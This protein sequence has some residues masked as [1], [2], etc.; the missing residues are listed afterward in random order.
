VNL[1]I[2]HDWWDG[3]TRVLA[4][5]VVLTIVPAACVLWFMNAAVTNDAAAAQERVL[6]AYRG[7]LH[8]VRSRLDALWRAQAERL[9]APGDPSREFQRLITNQIAEGAVVLDASGYVTFP[10]TD[11]RGDLAAID[12]RVAAAGHLDAAARDTAVTEIAARL[13]DY[14]KHLPAGDRLRLMDDLRAL[15]P[16]VWLPTQ[17]ALQLSLDMV[18][19]ERPEPVP[20][21]VRKA[22]VPD[23]WAL[24]SRDRR[25][26]GLYRTGRIEAILHDFLHQ[27][28]PEGVVFVAYPPDVV[29]DAEAI[30]AGP[31]LPGWQ[32]SMVPLDRTLF[33]GNA[34]RQRTI[35]VSVALGGIALMLVVGVI[36]GRSMRR[37]L[38]VARLKTDLA[39]AVSHELRTP[40]ASMRVLVDGLLADPSPDP[41]KTRDYLQLMAIENERLTRLIDNFLTF[42]R[43][44]RRPRRFELAPVS[45]ADLVH[46]ALD[47]VRARMPASCELRVDVQP[48]LP[49][50]LADQQGITTALVNL[51]DNAIKYSPADKRIAVS[52]RRDGDR[53]VSL[54][55]SDNGIG[56]AP[57]EQRRIFRRF[58]RVDQRLSSSTAGVGLGLSIVELIARG[59]GTSVTVE[60]EPGAGSTFT[61]RVRAAGEGVAA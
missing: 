38:Q 46:G 56:I 14:S 7:Q 5:L 37:H 42:S 12:A 39:A 10:W 61:L 25:T 49:L 19:S 30:A 29:A 44:E 4:L 13:N 43:L 2:G 24:T 60:S 23:I 6:V 47:A 52:A 41:G 50:V 3:H 32:L 9:D 34:G 20:D 58:Y 22:S 8:L 36:G 21:V 17:A 55:V 45:P 28:S 26:I 27:V 35:Y 54:A 51:L 40:L 57:R 48:Q 16:N 18:D 11:V 31:W 53:F 59:H 1:R 33:T 15:A